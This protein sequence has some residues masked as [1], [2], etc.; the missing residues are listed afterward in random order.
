MIN[1]CTVY[2]D[3]HEYDKLIYSPPNN[4]AYSKRDTCP[5][6][7]LHE[8]VT[9]DTFTESHT[10]NTR[11]EELCNVSSAYASAMC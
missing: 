2:V 10:V 1:S 6:R 5:I 3:T 8:C 4:A 9:V 7:R 11:P